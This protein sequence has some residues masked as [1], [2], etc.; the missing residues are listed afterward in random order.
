[1]NSNVVPYRWGG[2]PAKWLTGF[3][4]DIPT[5]FNADGSIDFAAFARLCEHQIEAGVHA[6]LICDTA[7]E[8]STLTPTERTQLIRTAVQTS[9]KRAHV[10]AGAGSNATRQAVELTRQAAAAGADAILSVVPYYNRP[11]QEGVFAHFRA[12]ADATA[13]P[14]ILHDCPARTA[15]ALSDDTLVRLAQSSQFVGL[16][17]ST[18][19]VARVAVLRARLPVGFRLLGGEDATALPFVAAG[20][21]GCIS[22]VVNVAPDLCSAMFAYAQRARW[23]AARRLYHQILPS[24]ECFARESPAALKYALSLQGLIRADVRLPLVGLDASAKTA[25]ADAIALLA[26]HTPADTPSKLRARA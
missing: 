17:D 2:H 12:V 22:Q 24:I 18:G 3:I 16:C 8:T 25:A 15:R 6:I 23:R 1:M 21:D 19:D 20:G 7:G 4:P 11:M 26:P 10:I 14:I 9:G 5:P 13:L